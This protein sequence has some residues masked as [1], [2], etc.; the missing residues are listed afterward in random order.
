MNIKI[1][2]IILSLASLNASA[3][4][5]YD[6]TSFLND[7]SIG[8]DLKS[9]MKNTVKAKPM[10]WTVHS[11][12]NCSTNSKSSKQLKGYYYYITGTK[13]RGVSCN[14][15]DGAGCIGAKPTTHSSCTVTQAAPQSWA[16]GSWGGCSTNSGS[17]KRKQGDYYY[18]S[19]TRYRGVSCDARDG[20]GC[21][22]SKPT[23]YTSCTVTQAAPRPWTIGSWGRC[24][25]GNQSNS[26]MHGGYYSFDGNKYRSVSCSAPSGVGCQ[27]SKPSTSTS[28][29]V[30]GY[31][32]NRGH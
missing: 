7:Y 14:A 5:T 3:G 4:S 21:I 29:T 10:P 11:W 12:G 9:S 19:G 25:I 31:A 28:C 13:Y 30:S 17:Y 2:A 18:I 23:S 16:V 15:F 1:I 8:V 27:G 6:S 26:G 20:A 24:D 22:G 32:P